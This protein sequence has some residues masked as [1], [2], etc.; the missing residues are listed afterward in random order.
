[1]LSGLLG[2][3]P[4]VVGPTCPWLSLSLERGERGEEMG[5]GQTA[6]LPAPKMFPMDHQQGN[7]P[8]TSL[9]PVWATQGPPGG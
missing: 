2:P 4:L 5:P 3:H 9:S 6:Q 8:F 1:M 7:I